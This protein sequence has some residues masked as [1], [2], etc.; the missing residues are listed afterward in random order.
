MFNLNQP[1]SGHSFDGQYIEFDEDNNIY[2]VPIL[3]K[4]KGNSSI[5]VSTG[6]KEVI[7]VQDMS[8][9][10]VSKEVFRVHVV[11]NLPYKIRDKVKFIPTDKIYFVHKVSDDILH[12]NNLANM[13]FPKLDNRPKVLYLGER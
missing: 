11:E 10:M 8:G 4:I 1:Y 9:T 2:K 5:G 7:Q 6:V 13:M 12:M 3:I